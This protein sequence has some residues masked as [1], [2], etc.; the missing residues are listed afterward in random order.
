MTESLP[1]PSPVIENDS[2]SHVVIDAG[3]LEF[4]A[5]D[6]TAT[7]L[8]TPYGV[9]SRS[10]IGE[11]TVEAGA[12]ELPE[13][14]TGAALNI[15]HKREDVVGGLSKLWEQE[16][17]L[18]ASFKFANTPEGRA[19]FA[20]AKEGKRK[21]L[22]VEASKVRI[23]DGKAISGRVFGAALVE[24]PAF[25]GAT[26][27]AAEDTPD[28][29]TDPDAYAAFLERVHADIAAALQLVAEELSKAPAEEPTPTAA[30]AEE[31]ESDDP[32]EIYMSDTTD[33]GAVPATL[34]A[35]APAAKDVD[36]STV[37]AAM[38]NVKNGT[39]SADSE[40]LLA[41]LADIT[42]PA[43]VTSGAIPETFAGK[44]WQGK[45]YNQRYI[46][47]ANHI[48]GGIA[49]GGR[50][51][52]KIDQG[53]AL[54]QE[55]A[56]A[57]QKVELPTG[58]ASTSLYGSTLRKFGFAADVALE[59]QYLEG[60]ADV[61][62]AFWEGVVDSGA[63]AIDEAALKDLFTVASRGTGAALSRLVA[64]ETYPTEYPAAMGQLIQG[65]ELIADNNDD[66]SFA[67]VNPV[68]WRQLLFTPKDQVPEFVEFG[69]GIG[70][71]EA[72][73]GKVRVVKAPQSFFTGTT[74]T[75]PQVLVG[76]KNAVEFREVH[77]DINALEVAKFGVD[78]ALVAFL[79]TFVVR[80]ESL[81][82]IGTKP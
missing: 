30:P 57:A 65:I 18:F 22:S 14:L 26:L 44:L 61:L 53:T 74:A 67:V 1:I 20:D 11:F 71:G 31:S 81:A 77:A 21:N 63:Q 72:S 24:R 47:L 25:E 2:L 76:A 60:G 70:S 50:K 28:P 16:Q 29:T 68:A 45:R 55:V 75:A 12:F 37:Y 82:L 40:T 43:H 38:S 62:A 46:S 41:A 59:W 5:E 6:L 17:G 79:E 52:W 39:Q 80:Q 34:L 73:T 4:S 10:N 8:L 19:A 42:T 54:V 51:G 33:A 9:K 36:L 7:G 23:R 27:L 64:P 69:V 58:S 49:L 3:T 32:K 66:A 56:N 15:E 35:S 78:R 13:D 48:Q